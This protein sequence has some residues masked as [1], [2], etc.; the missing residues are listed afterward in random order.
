MYNVEKPGFCTLLK[1]FDGRYRLPSCK[2]SSET[3]IPSLYSNGR[4]KLLEELSLIAVHF[5]ATTDFWS[6][7]PYISYT[8]H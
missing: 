7:A 3:A 2:Y 5:S 6:S 8:I 1:L 4:P